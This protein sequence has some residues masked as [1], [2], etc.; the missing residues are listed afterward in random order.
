MGDL[1]R[2]TRLEGGDGRYRGVL[3]A[4]WEG[5]GGVPAAGVLAALALRAAG[6][7]TSFRRP[8]SFAGHFVRT[9]RFGEVDLRVVPLHESE[10][11]AALRVTLTQS[12][13]PIL[14]ASVW[15]AAEAMPGYAVEF[16][17]I[18]EHP[19]PEGLP[20]ILEAAEQ[21]GNPLPPCWRHV[22]FRS[23]WREPGQA[24]APRDPVSMAWHRFVP[25]ANYDDAFVD[26]GRIVMLAELSA[27]SPLLFHSACYA[28]ELPYVTPCCELTV[29]LHRDTRK[30]DWLMLE[31]RVPAAESG[32]VHTQ[33]G[34]WARDGSLVAS[35]SGT[36]LCRTNTTAEAV[37][38]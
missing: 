29:Q 27:M 5:P 32:I 30:A 25:T 28:T 18:P 1:E 26:A 31:G 17:P 2:A 22:E 19:G 10:R 16:A 35:A 36:L 9:P 14:E 33:L 7:E 4:D 3:S 8:V 37:A 23:R 15:A 34:A 21:R 6:C 24:G 13:A 38:L 12:E 11:T 20:S